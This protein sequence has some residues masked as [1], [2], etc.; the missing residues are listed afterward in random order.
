MKDLKDSPD[1]VGNLWT[2]PDQALL[3]PRWSIFESIF[4]KAYLCERAL[5]QLPAQTCT[6]VMN[7][8][9]C[10]LKLLP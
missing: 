9:H 6:L 7:V 2:V 1:S 8:E 10:S 5:G 3:G 4:T